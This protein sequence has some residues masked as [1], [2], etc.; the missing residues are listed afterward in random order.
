MPNTKTCVACGN[1]AYPGSD[2]CRTCI[3]VLGD[4]MSYESVQHIIREKDKLI[5]EAQLEVERLRNERGRLM[6]DNDRLLNEAGHLRA[7]VEQLRAALG[8]ILDSVDYTDGAC[9]PNEQVGAVLPKCVINQARAA[10]GL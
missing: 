1:P 9:R 3:A 4:V 6:V 5:E 10:L 7:E 2:F 8:T